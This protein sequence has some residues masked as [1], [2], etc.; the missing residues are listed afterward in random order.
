VLTLVADESATA[1]DW[2]AAIHEATGS[3]EFHRGMAVLADARR[4]A[5]IPSTRD[6]FVRVEFMAEFS[7]GG[8]ISRWALVMAEGVQFGM[9]RM[10]EAY[11]NAFPT[12]FRVFT[13]L[14]EARLWAAGR[15]A[16]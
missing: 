7:K 10:A 1:E 5:R 13:S 9:G 15:P 6:V 2:T 8:R 12:P 14:D 4:M 16:S 11:A 3:P